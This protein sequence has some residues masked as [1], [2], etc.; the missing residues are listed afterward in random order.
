M[1]DL[2]D[3]IELIDL[4]PEDLRKRL[5]EGKVYTPEARQSRRA[6]LLPRG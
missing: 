6:E 2:A 5:A 1:L 4:P 3:E